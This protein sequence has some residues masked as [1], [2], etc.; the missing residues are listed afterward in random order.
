MPDVPSPISLD[1]E[2]FMR[3]ARAFATHFFRTREVP[4]L[5]SRPYRQEARPLSKNGLH[6][7]FL[8]QLGLVYAWKG[9][10]DV[11]QH[12]EV[13]VQD[14]ING[15]Q[16]AL[17]SDH[18]IDLSYPEKRDLGLLCDKMKM[19][20]ADYLRLEQ[21]EQREAEQTAREQPLKPQNDVGGRVIPL[22]P[23]IR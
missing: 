14:A 12:F 9:G 17:L 3:R 10:R 11:T 22:K 21:K 13:M 6:E 23:K 20:L 5:H 1:E 15:F 2:K 8:E 4:T 16:N 19:S 7:L 18:R